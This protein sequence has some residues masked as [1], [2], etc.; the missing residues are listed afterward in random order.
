MVSRRVSESDLTALISHE[1]VQ[2]YIL[3]EFLFCGLSGLL[4]AGPWRQLRLLLHAL[5]HAVL[6]QQW[7]PLR[8]STQVLPH[9]VIL[10]A[11]LR[12]CL[13]STSSSPPSSL[14]LLLRLLSSLSPP[15]L[16]HAPYAENCAVVVVGANRNIIRGGSQEKEIGGGRNELPQEKTFSELE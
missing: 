15:S 12:H 3:C 7:H 11:P 5:R 10:S 2:F 13:R 16:P 4:S 6:P 14:R 9:G 8:G 1:T